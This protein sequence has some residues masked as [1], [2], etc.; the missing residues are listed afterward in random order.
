[1]GGDVEDLVAMLEADIRQQ[2]LAARRPAH[3]GKAGRVVV[4][5]PSMGA[6][7]VFRPFVW[8]DIRSGRV[9]LFRWPLGW[10]HPGWASEVDKP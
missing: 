9:L 1:M 10:W 5:L 2:R 8:V 7:A 3:T 6:P 4:R